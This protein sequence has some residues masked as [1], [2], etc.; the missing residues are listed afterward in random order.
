[1][2]NPS[3]IVLL[4]T[5]TIAIPPLLLLVIVSASRVLLKAKSIDG[6]LVELM[7]IPLQLRV[8][9]EEG[10]N[11]IKEWDLSKGQNF[12][13]AWQLIWNCYFNEM[14]SCFQSIKANEDE[15]VANNWAGVNN[16]YNSRVNTNQLEFFVYFPPSLTVFWET[17]HEERK[18]N[19]N[20]SP[21]DEKEVIEFPSLIVINR[22]PISVRYYWLVVPITY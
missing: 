7:Q 18:N 6:A 21:W 10:T 12:F 16:C 20:I 1:M 19:S 4:S 17:R 15:G 2:K 14:L 8:E 9:L 3:T 5:R 22:N 11:W 13:M